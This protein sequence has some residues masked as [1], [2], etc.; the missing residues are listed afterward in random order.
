M[1][2]EIYAVISDGV[3]LLVIVLGDMASSGQEMRY[4]KVHMVMVCGNLGFFRIEGRSHRSHVVDGYR[5]LS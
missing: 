1:N 2:S 3:G 5:C 4:D